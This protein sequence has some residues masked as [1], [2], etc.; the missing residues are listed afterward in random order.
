MKRA[1]TAAALLSLAACGSTAEDF[2][3]AYAG[4]LVTRTTLGDNESTSAEKALISLRAID[5]ETLRLDDLDCSLDFKSTEDQIRF[6]LVAK[7]CEKESTRAE[8][9]SGSLYLSTNNNTVH[10]SFSG[11]KTSGSVISI[12]NTFTTSFTG[13]KQL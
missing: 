2:A 1:L 10:L 5:E 3:G 4:D 12:N 11:K 8:H 13:T 9:L 6:D 7:T